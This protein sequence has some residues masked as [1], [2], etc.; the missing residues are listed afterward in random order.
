MTGTL[1]QQTDYETLLRTFN[2]QLDE[3]LKKLRRVLEVNVEE[4]LRDIVIN[5]SALVNEIVDSDFSYS[6]DA[7]TTA[8]IT[9]A[10][11]GDGNQRAYN[12][13]RHTLATAL[14]VE[15][16]AHGLRAVGHSLYAANEGADAD[17]PDWDRVNGWARMGHTATAYSLDFPLPANI[18][19]PGSIF[20]FQLIC[21]LES[22]YSFPSGCQLAVGLHDNTVGQEKYLEAADVALAAAMTGVVGAVSLDYFLVATDDWG[23]KIKS[24]VKNVANANAALSAVNYVSLSWSKVDGAVDYTLYKKN[25]ATGIFYKV[26]QIQNGAT[27]YYDTGAYL[28][29]EAG[30]PA[31]TD[32]KPRAY[33]ETDPAGATLFSPP[34]GSWAIVPLTLHVPATY[35][36]SVTTGRQWVRVS[37]TDVAGNQRKIL[38]DHIGLGRVDGAWQESQLDKA[39]K[40]GISTSATSSTQGGT[41]SD[42]GGSDGRCPALTSRVTIINPVTGE[43]QRRQARF[44]KAGDA[45]LSPEGVS[46]VERVART[47]EQRGYELETEGGHRLVCSPTTPVLRSKTDRRGTPISK[48]RQGDKI[49]VFNERKNLFISERITCILRRRRRQVFC[50]ISLA[51]GRHT[52]VAE[53]VALHNVK[54]IGE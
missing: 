28:N 15:D 20:Y 27:T 29:V 24:N 43:L 21:S 16:D 8:G 45:V 23:H 2:S 34:S 40:S 3:R 22:A 17:I 36:M 25:N 52:Y 47:R 6:E 33:V 31:V 32:T 4:R 51:R 10:T 48:L 41:G 12:F 9:P 5:P 19:R 38:I 13:Y 42:S 26:A 46:I 30:F 49:L 50:E 53:G 1:H 39:A 11:A 44:L 54:L 18:A 7:F 35:D 37:L 14:L